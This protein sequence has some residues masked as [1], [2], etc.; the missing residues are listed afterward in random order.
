[1]TERIISDNIACAEKRG[2]CVTVTPARDTV[3][4]SGDG[5]SAGQILDRS[6]LFAAQ[7]PQSFRLSIICDAYQKLPAGTCPTD[8][9]GVC[10][11][12]GIPVAFVDGDSRNIKITSPADIAAAEAYCKED[13]YGE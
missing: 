2:A 5:K 12:A 10:L 1:M 4:E 11:L 13:F 6:R 9:G 3:Y 7:T 8:D